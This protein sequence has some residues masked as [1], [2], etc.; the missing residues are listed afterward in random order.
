MSALPDGNWAWLVVNISGGK[1][2]QTVL[3]EVIRRAGGSGFPTNRIV[4][5]HQCL[6]RMEWPGTLPL[7]REHAAHYGVRLEVTSYQNKALEAKTLLD[8]VRQ[9]GKWPSSAQRYCTSEFKRA[10]GGRVLTRL[11]RERP[12]DI[13]HVFGFRA[14]ESSS[15]RKRPVL[16]SRPRFATRE[17]SVWEWL[18]IHTWTEER[19]WE[20]IRTSGVPWHPAYDLGM[21]RLSC[22]F[23]IFAPRPALLIAGRANRELLDEYCDVEQ[24]IGHTFQNGRPIA[25]VRAAILAGELPGEMDGKWNM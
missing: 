1:D 23:C 2:S 4:A 11:S 16:V 6:G 19:V 9:R 22:C 24:A 5:S 14:E 7:V 18:P 3:R 10:P 12:G 21:P 25:E 17:R 15:R 13:L 8:Y 20:D